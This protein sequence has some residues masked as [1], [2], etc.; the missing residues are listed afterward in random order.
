[1]KF[2][3]TFIFCFLVILISINTAKSQDLQLDDDGRSYFVMQEPDTTYIM[4]Q[5][6]FCSLNAADG[7]DTLDHSK[8]EILEI[9]KGHMAHL[10]KL[11]EQGV[12]SI[13]GPYGD[14]GTSR[15]IMIMNCATLEDAQNYASQDPAVIAG[16]LV[17]DIRPIWLAQGSSL[18]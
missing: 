3:N 12:I 8:E 5:Y 16:R 2:F 6:F 15:G 10:G 14:A 18:K 17:I 13:A 4:Y 1:M 11:A 9:Q 7:R